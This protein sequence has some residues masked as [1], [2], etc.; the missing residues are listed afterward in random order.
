MTGYEH[1]VNGALDRYV[2]KMRKRGLDPEGVRVGTLARFAG[3]SNMT[4]GQ[5]LQSYRGLQGRRATRYVVAAE[6]YGTRARWSILGKPGDD[7][8]TVRDNRLRHATWYV[9]DASARAMSDAIHEVLPALHDDSADHKIAKTA[10]FVREQFGAVVR[11][12]EAML[13]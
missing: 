11:Y 9:G 10:T 12:V 13:S 6:N 1:V 8:K 3:V 2:A 5:Y 4:M 7:P